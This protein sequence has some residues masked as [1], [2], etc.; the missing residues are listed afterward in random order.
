VESGSLNGE[1][2]TDIT[3][4][5]DD[6]CPMHDT[7]HR[8]TAKPNQR[9][10]SWFVESP[11]VEDECVMYWKVNNREKRNEKMHEKRTIENQQNQRKRL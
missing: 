1:N 10:Q 2:M 9:W 5:K 8:Y 6:K 11:R 3:M 7:C 4:C